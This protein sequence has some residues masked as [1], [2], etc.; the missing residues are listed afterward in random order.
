LGTTSPHMVVPAT[1]AAQGR[2]E[3]RARRRRAV[4]ALFV[5][6]LMVVPPLV[7][8]VLARGTSPADG[9]LTHPAEW[10]AQGVVVQEIP[11]DVE[12]KGSADECTGSLRRGD[13]IT[14][15]EDESL[16][17]WVTGDVNRDIPRGDANYGVERKR[18][19]C[20]VT[21]N[22]G[23]YSWLS[24]IKSHALALPLVVVMW[25]IGAF[26]F[27]QRPRDSAAQA[28]FVMAV[29]LP[30]VGTAWLFGTQVIDLVNGPR[31][32]PLVVGE[33]AAALLW[34]AVLHFG[35]V[36]PRPVPFLRGHRR[37]T[38]LV[39][40]MPFVLYF[41][42]VAVHTIV[43]MAKADAA[44]LDR[45]SYLVTV[46]IASALV[47]PFVL[48]FVIAWQYRHAHDEAERRRVRWVVYTLLISAAVYLGLGQIPDLFGDPVV[49][50]DWQ[51]VVF[52]GVPLAL[53]AAVLQYGIFDLQIFLRRSLVYGTLTTLL[54]VVPA[55]L[56]V[57]LLALFG[58]NASGLD[59]AARLNVIL[60][61]A[62]FVAL[63]F[64]T[65]RQRVKRRVSR[66][67]FGDRDDPYEVVGQ[68]GG[69]LQSKVPAESLLATIAQTV[70]HALRLPYVAVE[71]VG[72][73]GVTDSQSYGEVQSDVQAVSLTSHGEEVGR[74]VLGSGAR[75]E[76]FGPA[77]QKLLELLAQQVGI[78]ADNVLLAARL[79]RSL[80]RAVSTREEERRRLRRDI[81]DGLGPMLA[82]GRMRLEVAHQLLSS[83]PDAAAGLLS[84]LVTAQQ[85]VI[86]DVRRLVDD[87]R[88]P[89]LDQLGLVQAIR[90]RAE[91]FSVRR[92]DGAGLQVTVDAS[93]DVEPLPAAV[94]VAT[95]RIVLEALTNVARHAQARHCHVRISR[96]EE[97]L[98]EVTDD[99]RGLPS[100]YRAGVGLNSMRERAS[101]MGGNC[102][103]TPGP[104]S[105]T[106]VRARLPIH[107][108]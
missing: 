105:G 50:Y 108:G 65:L 80:E 101:E 59:D 37:R 51:L 46:S 58:D 52:L 2:E 15:V 94:E 49:P 53:G 5:F 16:E 98:I 103:I 89:V 3:R 76:P 63:F 67:I 12:V 84:D 29:L 45:L 38:L 66:L 95:Y 60:G 73:D 48:A 92:D 6:V 79:Q 54:I 68:L 40:A 34:G 17:S 72:P 56:G 61:V 81:H 1:L 70:A 36:F 102:T 21:V 77:D 10:S 99:G 57:S 47:T 25:A 35:L 11:A 107:A 62:L 91:A 71:I 75:S 27:L 41:V 82:A 8:L 43:D 14:T 97:V 74:L 78:A 13:R 39:Y 42:N 19:S 22:I 18:K 100:A 69:Q 7:L 31:L 87:L 64:Q 30:Y 85:I 55:A 33:I 44:A 32:W 88:P 83:D 86:D 96:G 26:V 106:V 90:E 23:T 4:L 93:P 104:E 9:T 20:D 24:Q 28:L